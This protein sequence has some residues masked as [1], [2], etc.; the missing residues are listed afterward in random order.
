MER[1]AAPAGV[2][3]RLRVVPRAADSACCSFE[4]PCPALA[5]HFQFL[6]VVIGAS[7]LHPHLPP[8]LPPSSPTPPFLSRFDRE[9]VFPLPNLSAR[10][11]ILGI[12]TRKWAEPP[13]NELLQELASLAVGYCG[14]DLKV[15]L[16]A[17][18]ACGAG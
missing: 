8:H 15:G 4:L 6:M 16:G 5:E 13:S 3:A 7:T 11:D 14:A 9:L 10:A 12:H 18:R 17:G 2:C 1:C